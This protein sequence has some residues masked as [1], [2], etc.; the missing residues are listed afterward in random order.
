MTLK[1][2]DVTPE[3]NCIQ[4]VWEMLL[5]QTLMSISFGSCD[6]W[7]VITDFVEISEI[8]IDHTHNKTP[9]IAYSNNGSVNRTQ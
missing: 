6:H 4:C 5:L 9:V 3:E 8:T 2:L 7:K 1:T